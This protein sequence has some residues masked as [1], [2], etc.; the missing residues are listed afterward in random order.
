MEMARKEVEDAESFLKETEDRLEVIDVDNVVNDL[1]GSKKRRKL[2]MSSE[3]SDRVA[4]E[5][6]NSDVAV[7]DI[8]TAA[9]STDRQSNSSDNSADRQNTTVQT[10]SRRG[11]EEVQG[12]ALEQHRAE[13]EAAVNSHR[14]DTLQLLRESGTMGESIIPKEKMTATRTK[15]VSMM[16]AADLM[17]SRVGG[18]MLT[19][20]EMT[21]RFLNAEVQAVVFYRST[22]EGA[23][24][25]TSNIRQSNG[26][27]N[28]AARQTNGSDNSAARQTTVVQRMHQS[29]QNGGVCIRHGASQSASIN[30]DADN[31]KNRSSDG[32]DNQERNNVGNTMLLLNHDTNI[33]KEDSVANVGVKK[34]EDED[35]D[36]EN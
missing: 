1:Q 20:A 6:N 16:A 23:T 24:V 18:I 30:S 29:C 34:E 11:R 8:G 28:S 9:T 12:N 10:F 26:S 15:N 22:K 4:V 25:A 17:A 5:N 21:A 3:G 35:T 36:N 33:G 14:D 27:D 31:E 19:K 7:I 2:S 32:V 13:F